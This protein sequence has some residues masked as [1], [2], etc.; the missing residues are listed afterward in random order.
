[1]V[2]QPRPDFLGE[3]IKGFDNFDIHQQTIFHR[4]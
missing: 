4:R 3:S 2:D 1:M